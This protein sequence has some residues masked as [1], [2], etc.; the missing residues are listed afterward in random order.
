MRWDWVGVNFIG[1]YYRWFV[2]RAIMLHSTFF[3]KRQTLRLSHWSGILL[4][5]A[6]IPLVAGCTSTPLGRPGVVMTC[7]GAARI[8]SVDPF[9]FAARA[10]WR[11]RRVTLWWDNYSVLFFG[12]KR[13]STLVAKPGQ[14]LHFEGLLADGDIYLGREW[15]GSPPPPFGGEQPFVQQG[16]WPAN[17]PKPKKLP[18]G[19]VIPPGKSAGVPASIGP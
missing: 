18:P 3:S 6:T 12:G 11:G 16:S 2:T 9:M 17:V 15:I 1:F 4:L 7:K 8:L 13:T 10:T 19:K 14:R 5:A